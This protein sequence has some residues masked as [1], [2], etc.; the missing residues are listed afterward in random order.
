MELRPLCYPLMF[1]LL[2]GCLGCQ[3]QKENEAGAGNLPRLLLFC[4][5]GIQMPVSELV[6][7][8]NR[9]RHCRI[10]VDY[11]GSEV[12]LSRITLKKRGDLY[13]PGDRSYVDIAADGGMIDS[14]TVACYFVPAILVSKGNP[15]RITSLRD[16]TADGIRLGLGDAKACAV[17]RQ[18]KKIFAKNRIPWTNIERNLVFQS[19]TVNELG[20]QIQTGSLDAVIVWDAVASQYLDHGELVPIPVEQNIISEVPVGILDF[21]QHKDLAEQFAEFVTSEQGRAVFRKYYFRVDPPS[22]RDH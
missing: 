14:S 22:N 19:M 21:S 7:S 16:L 10:E 1:A 15:K 17:G 11:A 9:S 5:A 3:Q 6:E 4:G 20:L 18:S 12:L 8:F 13:M 2:A